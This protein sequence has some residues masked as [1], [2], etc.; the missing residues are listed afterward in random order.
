MDNRKRQAVQ[1][2]STLLHNA[3]LKGF[4]TGKIYTGPLKQLCVPGLNCYSCPGAA[5]ACPLGSLQSF[6]AART[7][8]LPYYILGLLVFFG[9]LLG[10]A[11]CGFLCPF[12][13]LQE[14]LYRVPFFRKGNRFRADRKLR[15]V[16]YAVLLLLV[17]VLPLSFTLI[18]FFCKYLCPAG[19]ISG[20][21]L[22]AYDRGIRAQLGGIFLWKLTLL[23]LIL[24]GSLTIFR[25]FC[26]YLCPLGAI[27]GFFN[28]V[29]L[30]RLH[31]DAGKCIRCGRCA[32]A[33]DMCVDP[34]TEPDSMECIRCGQC[35]AQC[36]EQALQLT[37]RKT[38][39]TKK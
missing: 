33:C 18:P 10:R 19:T 17:I 36:P 38:D 39:K 9:A 20:I 7:F 31:C 23:V 26:K 27:Y 14:L 16:K 12:G 3:N 11:V 35:A 25:F 34:V 37:F 22:A 15:K 8:R 6:L 30:L 24:I 5:G 32:A 2:I 21:L 4:L 28:R 1:A 13:W 29:S